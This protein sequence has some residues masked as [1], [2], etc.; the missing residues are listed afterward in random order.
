MYTFPVH[1]VKVEFN[2]E[3]FVAIAALKSTKLFNPREKPNQKRS[4]NF[5]KI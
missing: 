3:K 1:C 5:K 4:V 2:I